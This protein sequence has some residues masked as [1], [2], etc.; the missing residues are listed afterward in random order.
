MR[1]ATVIGRMI[2]IIMI[3]LI[4]IIITRTISAII[5]IIIVIIPVPMLAQPSN[6]I[7]V[8]LSIATISTRHTMMGVVVMIRVF[9]VAVLPEDFHSLLKGASIIAKKKKNEN[10]IFPL[11]LRKTIFYSI[12]ST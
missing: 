7:T 3:I 1:R 10:A 5:V 4:I 2:T 11:L 12:H 9:R 6:R 8:L